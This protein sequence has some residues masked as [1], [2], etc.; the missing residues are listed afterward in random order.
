MANP[1]HQH[2]MLDALHGY[3]QKHGQ[4]AVRALLERVA[5]VTAAS[6]VPENK[7]QAVISAC[8]KDTPVHAPVRSLRAH[9][10]VESI[11]GK[12]FANWNNP[13]QREP[14]E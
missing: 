13:P 10:G 14:T 6:D 11:V 4:P 2:V 7:M 3:K 12:A 1:Q 8:V 5:G 9:R